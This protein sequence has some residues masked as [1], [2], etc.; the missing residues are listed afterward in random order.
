MAENESEEDKVVVK[1]R[2]EMTDEEEQ[3]AEDFDDDNPEESEEIED[4]P[5]DEPCDPLTMSCDEMRDEII[6]LTG[7]RTQYEDTIRKLSDVKEV[8][9]S[10]GIDNAYEE[11]LKKRQ[12]VDDEIYGTF[13]KFMVC[14]KNAPERTR[15]EDEDT[16]NE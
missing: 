7:K 4:I 2:E 10:E 1:S 16:E 8:L 15:I 13:E 6:S 5:D 12:E 11:A 9:P 14:S 3:T